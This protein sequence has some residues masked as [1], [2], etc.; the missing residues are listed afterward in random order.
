MSALANPRKPIFDA[1]RAVARPGLFNDPGYVTALDNLLDAF[2][3]ARA[4]PPAPAPVPAAPPADGRRRINAAGLEILK[5]AEGLELKAY[6]CPAGKWTIGYGSTGAHVKPGMVITEAEADVLLALDLDRFERWVERH[7]QP[8]TDNQFSALVSFAFNLGEGAL[9]DS[10]LRRKHQAGDY[11]GA[12]A[13]F[14]RWNK[15][16]VKGVLKVLPGLTA[17]RAAEAALYRKG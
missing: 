12:A 9:A 17:R 4:A 1:V 5:D 15:A 2:G 6:V 11:A 14:A 10:T 3:V 8:A 13:E 7:C 16:K